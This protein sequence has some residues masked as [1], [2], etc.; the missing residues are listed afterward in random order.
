VF[1]E[2]VGIQIMEGKVENLDLGFASF[3]ADQIVQKVETPSKTPK[4]GQKLGH[5]YFFDAY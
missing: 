3:T 2:C 1:L 5:Y 4:I